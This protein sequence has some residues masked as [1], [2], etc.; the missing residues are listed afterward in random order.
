MQNARDTIRY[1]SALE[2]H[3]VASKRNEFLEVIDLERRTIT[4]LAKANSYPANAVN[5]DAAIK[6]RSLSADL[7]NPILAGKEWVS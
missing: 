3:I 1:K 4:T 6:F 7:S 5:G 2:G